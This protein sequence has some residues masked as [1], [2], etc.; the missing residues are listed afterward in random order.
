MKEFIENEVIP[1]FSADF[2]TLAFDNLAIK[3]LELDVKN[4]YK[5]LYQGDDGKFSF[6]IDA[7]K[8][9]FAKSSLEEKQNWYFNLDDAFED[10]KRGE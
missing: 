10:I 2:K 5:D 4:K 7:V 1:D 8:E 6:Y 3:Q 9:V